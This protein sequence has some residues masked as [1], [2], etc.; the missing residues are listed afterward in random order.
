MWLSKC[1]EYVRITIMCPPAIATPAKV[2]KLA[3]SIANYAHHDDSGGVK[4]LEGGNERKCK[5]TL[6]AADW[7]ARRGAS[8]ASFRQLCQ[9]NQ[10]G[11]GQTT[12]L[13]F[14]YRITASQVATA[15][16]QLGDFNLL[17][18]SAPML[19]G[20]RTEHGEEA[21]QKAS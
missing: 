17:G 10:V 15:E 3:V 11:Q 2:C 14:V 6:C 20:S 12:D 18:R 16:T 13:P 8:N 21:G 4:V 7:Q 19:S 5:R 1:S 9:S